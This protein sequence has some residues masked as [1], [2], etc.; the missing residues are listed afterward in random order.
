[1]ADRAARSLRIC[2]CSDLT[3]VREKDFSA[4]VFLE[5]AS[6]SFR[7]ERRSARPDFPRVGEFFFLLEDV[8]DDDDFVPK[9]PPKPPPPP[10]VVD[11]FLSLRDE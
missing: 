11:F 8:E 3:K 2:S 10:P 7:A 9:P 1:V 4:F 5:E 6:S